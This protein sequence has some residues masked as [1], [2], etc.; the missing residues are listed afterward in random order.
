MHARN[1]PSLGL[2]GHR[3]LVGLEQVPQAS[4][5]RIGCCRRRVQA[6]ALPPMPSHGHAMFPAA[7]D[8]KAPWMSLLST[9]YAQMELP[10]FYQSR[11]QFLHLFWCSVLLLRLKQAKSGYTFWY[12]K[13][14]EGDG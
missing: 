9:I 14:I 11:P 8:V 12:R 6:R 4:D 2:L 7:L 10:Y 1:V 3:R 5:A 13:G